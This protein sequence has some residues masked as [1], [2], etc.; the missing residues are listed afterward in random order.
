MLLLE[1]MTCDEMQPNVAEMQVNVV[2]WLEVTCVSSEVIQ[3]HQVQP[4]V[5]GCLEVTCVSSEV[6]K[7]HQ[8]HR[9][10]YF[11]VAGSGM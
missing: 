2:G 11:R 3:S 1:C 5:S 9:S 10:K 7:S 4:N 6:I 8:V